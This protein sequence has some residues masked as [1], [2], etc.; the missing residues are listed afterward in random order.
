MGG[1]DVVALR[2]ICAHY[3]EMHVTPLLAEVKQS[4]QQLRAQLKEVLDALEQKACASD[5]PTLERFDRLVIDLSQ[6]A[7]IADVDESIARMTE[8]VPTFAKLDDWLDEAE[9]KLRD[10]SLASISQLEERAAKTERTIRSHA[11][12]IEEFKEIGQEMQCK[13]NVRD[14]PSLVQFQRLATTVERKANTSKVPTA[15]QFAELQEIVERKVDSNLVPTISQFE[16]VAAELEKKCDSRRCTAEFRSI[17]EELEKKADIATCPT[18]A[19]V[20]EELEI[21]ETGFRDRVFLTLAPVIEK[22]LASLTAKVQKNSEILDNVVSNNQPQVAQQPQQPTYMCYV[23]VATCGTWGYVN[24][25]ESPPSCAAWQSTHDLRD[26][27]SA[28]GRQELTM[29]SHN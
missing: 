9:Q 2:A 1:Y 13:A 8:K 15:A 12:K 17:Q 23:P 21:F 10:R 16:Q 14:V 25:P 5:T 6:K 3:V 24:T 22:R 4:H 20:K 7:S 28:G 26:T 18:E 11:A 29:E 19:W 27:V